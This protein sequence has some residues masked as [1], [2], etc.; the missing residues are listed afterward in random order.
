STP[1]R[2]GRTPGP[3]GSGRPQVGERRREDPTFTLP[4]SGGPRTG[5]GDGQ[6]E[7]RSDTF[8]TP[9]GRRSPLPGSRDPRGGDPNTGRP[10]LPGTGGIQPGGSG[11]GRSGTGSGSTDPRRLPGAGRGHDDPLPGSGGIR[12]PERGGSDPGRG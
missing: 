10:T 3:S 1:G 12:T 5:A 2:A 6:P 8:R 11:G 9:E 4:R 7:G